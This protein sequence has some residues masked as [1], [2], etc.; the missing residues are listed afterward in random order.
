MAS[1]DRLHHATRAIASA[2]QPA[3]ALALALALANDPPSD[4]NPREWLTIAE[5][6]EARSHAE[7]Q[8]LA[9]RVVAYEHLDAPR[10][11]VDALRT[12]AQLIAA[13]GDDPTDPFRSSSLFVER[14]DAFVGADTPREALACYQA[15]RATIFRVP[16]GE[17]AWLEARDVF[18]RSRRLRDFARALAI[19]VR[20]EIPIPARLR[21]WVEWA[22]LREEEF[23]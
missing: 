6:V 21:S 23:P 17:P 20:A 10:A 12:R 8:W 14:A 15:S 19:L 1:P 5:A 11:P 22:G 18:L 3:E 16:Q 13:L 2:S 4:W 7:P 9:I